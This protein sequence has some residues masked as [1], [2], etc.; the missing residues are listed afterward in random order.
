VIGETQVGLVAKKFAHRRLAEG[1]PIAFDG[2]AGY[3][4]VLLMPGVRFKLWPMFSV[5]KHP[6]V[7]IP[8]GAI[9]V[10]IAQ[11]GHPLPTGAKSAV[12]RPEFGDFTDLET[13]LGN[14]GQKGVQ[15]KVL[16]PG[17]LAPI[18]PV[19][20]IVLS[21][22]RAYGIPVDPEYAKQAKEAGGLTAE[23]FGLDAEQLAV[24]VIEPQRNEDDALVD[25]VGIVTTLEG[26]APAEGDIASRIGGWGDVASREAQADAATDSELI[27]AVLG[28][29]NSVHDNYQDYQAF[30]DA[31]G[32][33]GLQHDP[34]LYGSYLLNPFLVSVDLVPMLVVQQ[35]QVAVVKAYVGLPTVDTSGTEFKY[36]SIVR[37]GHRGVWSE[38]L[39]TGKYPINPRCYAAEIVPTSILTLNW[40]TNVTSAHQLDRHLSSISGKSREGFEFSIDLQVQIHVPDTKASRVV[41]ATGTIRNLVDDV[42]QG[43]VANYFR[44]VL[45]ALPAVRFIETREDVQ[46]AAHSQIAQYLAAYEVETRGVYIQDVIFPPTLV[47]VLTKREIANQEKET[48]AQQQQAQQARVA[49]EAARGTA[50]M[51]AQLATATVSVDIERNKAEARKASAD[52]EAAYV[53]ATGEA[54]A[55]RTKALALAE[56][57]GIRAAGLARADGYREQVGALGAGATAVVNV[58]NAVSDGHVKVAPDVLVTG[59]G[60]GSVDGV[61]G[62]LMQTLN[63]HRGAPA[64]A[65]EPTLESG[66]GPTPEPGENGQIQ[67]QP[68][69]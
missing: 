42:L 41:S 52:G 62:L 22:D 2:E 5:S 45:Q 8:A 31:G 57:E 20:F 59:G 60:G 24:T 49:V 26:P 37:P 19:A 48:Y 27:E 36:G 55:D 61:L 16:A 7:Q 10:V 50:D 51:Q 64:V 12:Y 46:A 58:A 44:N 40:A 43:A 63:G 17:M 1:N 53:R 18:H 66:T 28:S 25:V 54:E 21:S 47:D 69:S 33:I 34:L 35:G 32:R 29:K 15:R 3:Q 14:G 9:G 56:A 39:R 6:W 4:A 67:E 65:I 38:P 13:F 68:P 23:A 11:A 30:L